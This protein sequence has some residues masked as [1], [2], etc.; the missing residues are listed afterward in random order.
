M[1]T[2]GLCSFVMA[3]ATYVAFDTCRLKFTRV[4]VCDVR[5]RACFDVQRGRYVQGVMDDD[6]DFGR[7]GRYVVRR[8]RLPARA[9]DSFKLIGP[10]LRP[11]ELVDEYL[12]W[13]TD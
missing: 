5:K 3:R 11:V 13:L 1:P 6:D 8:V 7:V 4:G 12:A 10:D 9:A 2:E